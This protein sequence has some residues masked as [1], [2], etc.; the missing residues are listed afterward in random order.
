MDR[1]MKIDSYRLHV[2]YMLV[3]MPMCLIINLYDFA[4]FYYIDLNV[5]DNALVS[6]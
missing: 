1:S 3:S 4:Y 5:E 2:S 6:R